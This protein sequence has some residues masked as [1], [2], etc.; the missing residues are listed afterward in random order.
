MNL[1]VLGRTDHPPP[2]YSSLFS[3]SFCQPITN[4]DNSPKNPQRIFYSAF[5]FVNIEQRGI[6]LWP[7]KDDQM[8]QIY[9]SFHLHWFFCRFCKPFLVRGFTN[10]QNNITSRNTGQDF[11]SVRFLCTQTHIESSTIVLSLY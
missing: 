9:W 7:L 4:Y 5:L 6:I 10:C 2:Y 11:K 8:P 1:L 3:A